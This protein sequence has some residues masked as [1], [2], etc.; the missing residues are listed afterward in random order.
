MFDGVT[1]QFD[2][3]ACVSM[4]VSSV[5]GEFFVQS[6]ISNQSKNYNRL[7]SNVSFKR[8]LYNSL[9]WP[10]YIFD[11]V[12]ITKSAKQLIIALVSQ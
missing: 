12:D 7:L 2:N 3:K 9:R 5:L 1:H 8:Q 10:I 4:K 6:L 11:L